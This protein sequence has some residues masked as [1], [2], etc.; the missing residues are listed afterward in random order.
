[1][2]TVATRR[3]AYTANVDGAAASTNAR[4]VLCISSISPIKT[5]E[6]PFTNIRKLSAVP[7][8]INNYYVPQL[9]VD[10]GLPVTIIRSDLW[11]KRPIQW[12]PSRKRL[13]TFNE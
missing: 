12:Q 2:S 4:P 10:S 6:S 11:N 13:K 9:L 3:Y 7:G 8:K 5:P 1:M